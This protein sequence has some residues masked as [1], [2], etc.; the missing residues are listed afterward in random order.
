MTRRPSWKTYSRGDTW[1]DGIY[2]YAHYHSRIHEV[3][4]IA[5]GKG[6]V[7]LGGRKGRIIRL[8]A[9]DVAILP[10]GTGHQCLS[11]EEDFL[12]VGGYP[13]VGT[14]DECTELEDRPKALR[15]IPKVPVPRKDPIYGAAGPLLQLWKKPR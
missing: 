1:R 4:G 14:Y 10:A 5:R 8:K 7:R 15:T 2:D 12:V 3:L 9:G 6:R 13:P 11:V